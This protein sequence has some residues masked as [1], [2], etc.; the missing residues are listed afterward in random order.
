MQLRRQIKDWFRSEGSPETRG[1]ALVPDDK[2]EGFLPELEEILQN[3]KTK[4]FTDLR[5]RVLPVIAKIHK[6]ASR[7]FKPNMFSKHYWSDFKKRHDQINK[8]WKQLPRTKPQNIAIP[9]K[10]SLIDKKE[11]DQRQDEGRLE[12]EKTSTAKHSLEGA[13]MLKDS[14]GDALL[15]RE[16][17]NLSRFGSTQA[18]DSGS[19]DMMLEE[20]FAKNQCQDNTQEIANS[21]DMSV[22]R[23]H[24]EGIN[25]QLSTNYLT[26]LNQTKKLG[27]KD[28]ELIKRYLPELATIK[29]IHHAKGLIQNNND[30]GPLTKTIIL[31]VLDRYFMD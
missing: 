26:E 10:D 27:I 12:E 22:I 9:A 7:E 4:S 2:L 11:M 1:S 14:H 28:W 16:S 24:E 30:H 31:R 20:E 29:D 8:L 3:M 21:I 19:R 15:R 23:S 18:S 6:K 5:D 17:C 25:S 13:L